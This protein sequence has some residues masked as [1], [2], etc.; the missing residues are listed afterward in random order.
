MTNARPRERR[1]TANSKV[2]LRGQFTIISED[3]DGH[4]GDDDGVDD[5]GD[6]GD[7]MMVMM[8]MIIGNC[9]H[10]HVSPISSI[11]MTEKIDRVN[12][13]D[14]ASSILKLVSL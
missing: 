3:H 1:N 11:I 10:T 9:V 13:A 8:V 14:S 2:K 5:G 6:D 4:N 7:D 12:C